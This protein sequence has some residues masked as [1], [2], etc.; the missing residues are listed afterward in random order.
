[1]KTTLK[2]IKYTSIY[3]KDTPD[4]KETI[5]KWDCELIE[6][7]TYCEVIPKVREVSVEFED[8]SGFLYIDSDILYAEIQGNISEEI[9][10]YSIEID[11]KCG[12][13]YVQVN[14]GKN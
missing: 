2:G 6:Y 3:G 5:I 12:D 13:P 14:F 10:P 1:M 9:F 7:N 4:V 11:Y 8:G